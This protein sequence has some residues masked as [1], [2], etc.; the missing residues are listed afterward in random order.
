MFD[1][2]KQPSF[3]LAVTSPKKVHF[4]GAVVDRI[5]NLEL[6]SSRGIKIC[7]PKGKK[8]SNFYMHVSAKG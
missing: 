7:F 3:L 1:I 5:A 8:I 4:S 2:F 6:L